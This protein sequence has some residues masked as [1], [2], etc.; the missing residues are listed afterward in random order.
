MIHNNVWDNISFSKMSS[1]DR[2]CSTT[3]GNV[4]GGLELQNK[5]KERTKTIWG[6]KD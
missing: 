5:G 4:H 6:G 1:R 3:W 2:P